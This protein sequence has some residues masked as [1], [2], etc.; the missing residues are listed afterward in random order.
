MATQRRGLGRGLDA[1]LS[2]VEAAA[3]VPQRGERLL[4]VPI[5]HLQRGRFQPRKDIRSDAL[6]ELA[7]SIRVQ[8]IVQPLIVRRIAPERYE[9]VAGERRWRAA[10]I[11]G[12]AEVPVVVREVTDQ[13]AIAVALIENIQR[14]D[15]NA[16]EE[17]E[18][19][20]RLT[21]E[22]QLTHAEA[23]TAVG[24]SRVTVTNL[25]RLLEL[26]PD[27]QQLVRAGKLQMG[28]ARALL[29][30]AE[31][32][33]TEAAHRIVARELTAREAEALV[34]RIKAPAAAQVAQ[35]ADPNVAALER[36]L[37][38][39]LGTRVTV[40]TRGQG[41]GRLVIRYSSLDQL[42]GILDRLRR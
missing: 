17:A 42:D 20:A 4:K 34:R 14:Q 31:R 18:A 6:A 26:T 13:A 9:I 19:L 41:K 38:E 30:L 32:D 12:L 8:G 28:H 15:L 5:E 11:A 25:L 7:D 36:E 10:Q 2:G 24:R 39:K 23:A 40:Q 35:R 29:G 27:V 21:S 1:L 3:E 33:Q 37:G 16:L 22:F